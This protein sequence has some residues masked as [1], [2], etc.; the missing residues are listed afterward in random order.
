MSNKY[1]LEILTPERQFYIGDVEAIMFEAPDG[2]VSIL[3]DHAPFV[4]P[5]VVGTLRIRE[6]DEW[7]DAFCSEGFIEVYHGNVV[8]FVQACEWPENI[9][10]R[11]AEAAERRAR[12]QLRQQRSMQEYRRFQIS[13]AR[14]M[15]RLRITHTKINLD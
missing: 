11:R 5:I 13:L 15:V 14:A 6:D 1:H 4:A 9:D 8:V 12:E 10:V 7:R 2:Q 3:A